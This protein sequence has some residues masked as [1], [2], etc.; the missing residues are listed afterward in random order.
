ML[1]LLLTSLL[2][3]YLAWNL[4]ANDVAN[5]M[6]TSVGS[7][8]VTLRQAL[9]IAG[10]LE[11]AGAVLF[12][13]DVS[14]TLATKIVNPAL[15]AQ[16]PQTLLVGMVSVLIACSVWLNLAT[17]K[18]L[19][20]S[21]S[22]AVVG[23]IAGFACVAIGSQAVDWRSI[24]I[25]SLTWIITPAISGAIAALFYS[26][27]KRWIL[28]QPDAI[29]Q[30]REWIPWLSV[31]LLGSFGVIVLPTV[32]ERFAVALPLPSHTISLAIGAIAAT[33]LTFSSWHYLEAREAG[34]SV[35]QLKTPFGLSS[36]R[37]QNSELK[38]SFSSPAESLMARFQL[39]S[40]CFVA[41]AHGSNDVGNAVAPLAAIVYIAQTGIVPLE[42]FQVPLWIL[43]L[44]G[45]GIV[46]GLAVWGKKVIATIGEGIIPLQPSGG[47][48]AELATA[49]TILLASRLGLPVS[50]SHALV[51]GVVGIGLVQGMKSIRLQTLRAIGLAWVVTLPVAAGLSALIFSLSHWF[52][53]FR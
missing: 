48:C 13:R 27:I 10:I 2:A 19:P 17:L 46:T 44:G 11:F 39:L 49:T 18:G 40:A 52:L 4:G 50:T 1:L 31:A 45:V 43:V 51:G 24:G 35:L 38:T 29:A 47:F 23:A 25:I 26:Q 22:H 12:G 5:S 42:N 32:V 21:S 37:K 7:K 41:F 34:S 15:F 6:G 36:G 53:P 30:L 8:A 14:A 33:S 16:S 9:V 20:V 28:D 3:F